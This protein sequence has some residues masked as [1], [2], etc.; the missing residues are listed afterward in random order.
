MYIFCLL[1]WW[2]ISRKDPPKDSINPLRVFMNAQ[3]SQGVLKKM[4]H[5]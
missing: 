1:G 5:S 3:A 4:S 2:V